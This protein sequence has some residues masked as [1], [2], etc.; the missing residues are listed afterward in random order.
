[1]DLTAASAAYAAS[2][3]REDNSGLFVWAFLGLCALIVVVQFIPAVLLLFG[4]VKGMSK[5][6]P[7][8]EETGTN[9]I[10]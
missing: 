1:M 4:F 5:E 3:A 6:K 7:V 9:R 2:S 8:E 10:E